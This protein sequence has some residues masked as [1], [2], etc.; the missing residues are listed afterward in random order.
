MNASSFRKLKV[1][2]LCSLVAVI[3]YTFAGTVAD[4]AQTKRQQPPASKETAPPPKID[5]NDPSSVIYLDSAGKP[6]GIGD[7]NK[8]ASEAF[9]AGMGWHPQALSAAGLPKD[10]YGLVDWAKLVR[11]NIINPKH[12]LDPAEEEAPPLKMDVVIPA[13]GDFVDDVIY[14]HEMHTYWLKCDVCHPQIFVPARGANEMTMVGIVKGDWCGR[15]HGKVAFPL[16]DCN[17]CHSVPKNKA[18]KK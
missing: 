6:A 13:K 9:K 11:Q 2:L 3:G 1:A 15:C 7:P 18:S 14:P 17:K 4:A 12:S 16:T 8:P 5:P 10:R